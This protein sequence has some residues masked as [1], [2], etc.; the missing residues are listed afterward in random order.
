MQSKLILKAYK[1]AFRL[2]TLHNILLCIRG[3][4]KASH[5][6]PWGV[7]FVGKP[8]PIISAFKRREIIESKALSRMPSD[9]ICFNSL[10]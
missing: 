4:C 6:P 3:L 1:T 5:N 2:I 9:H 7:P 10:A 8:S